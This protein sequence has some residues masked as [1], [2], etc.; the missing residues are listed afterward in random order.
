M[1]TRI[2]SAA[3]GI[4][5]EPCQRIAR[6]K[7]PQIG[8]ERLL[9]L[10]RR[11]VGTA[12]DG[13]KRGQISV[14][15]KRAEHH[16]PGKQHRD[17]AWPIVAAG[18]TSATACLFKVLPIPLGRRV[19]PSATRDPGNGRSTATGGTLAHPLAGR[20][21]SRPPQPDEFGD[22]KKDWAPPGANPHPHEF[23]GVPPSGVG[24]ARMIFVG[25][26]FALMAARRNNDATEN[27]MTPP[28]RTSMAMAM[29]GLT[30]GGCRLIPLMLSFAVG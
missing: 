22:A 11:R 10:Y 24:L 3:E 4:G 18:G 6:Y 1:P 5:V 2:T 19:R 17:A 12:A 29:T 26:A 25:L 20:H 23:D 27:A 16:Q 21:D 15:R 28:T 13:G 8:R 14:D 9:H 30:R 7:H